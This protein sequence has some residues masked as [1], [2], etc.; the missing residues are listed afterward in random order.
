[1]TQKN[2]RWYGAVNRREAGFLGNYWPRKM[3]AYFPRFRAKIYRFVVN[4]LNT[5]TV[6]SQPRLKRTHTWP[7]AIRMGVFSCPLRTKSH[8]A[9]Q[10]CTYRSDP[11]HLLRLSRQKPVWEE[12]TWN[13]FWTCDAASA[14]FQNFP[15]RVFPA[16]L[17]FSSIT[18]QRWIGWSM[19]LLVWKKYEHIQCSTEW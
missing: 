17:F 4:Y 11:P 6:Y 19:S 5:L 8:S 3:N 9:V 1:M 10:W 18:T 2:W 7:P 12:K 14:C 13:I 15:K 16:S